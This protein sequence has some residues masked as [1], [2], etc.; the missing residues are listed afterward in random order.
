MKNSIKQ[1]CKNFDMGNDRI[2]Q[3]SQDFCKPFGITI[4]A[5]GRRYNDATVSWLTTNPDQDRFLLEANSLEE[6]PLFDM[7]KPIIE[8]TYLWFNDRKFLGCEAFYK[9]R[10]RLFQM[11]H[12]LVLIKNKKNYV[13]FS[14]YSGLLAKRPLYNLFVNEKGLFNAFLD[15]F[16][17]KL[18]RRLVGLLEDGIHI[19]NFRSNSGKSS[20]DWSLEDRE[21]LI[22]TCGWSNLLKLSKREKESLLLY[23]EG[24]TYNEIGIDLRL[25][26]RT[27]EHYLES[28][29]NK[30]NIDNRAELYLAAEKLIQLGIKI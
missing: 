27:V 3:L 25:S 2:R 21:S 11:D 13:E 24:K 4:F 10:E 29:K 28:V 19:E 12:G 1:F 14:C 20:Q 30:L 9:D 18:D 17:T 8:G 7:S 6:E 26:E 22:I 23:R 5:Y 15:N 16:V